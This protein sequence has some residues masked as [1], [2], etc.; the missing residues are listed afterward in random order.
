MQKKINIKIKLKADIAS[1]IIRL[2]NSA[3]KLINYILWPLNKNKNI[4]KICIHR[5]GAIG[6]MLCILPAIYSIRKKYPE[7]HI[8]LLTSTGKNATSGISNFAAALPW[9][10]CIENYVVQNKTFE[11]MLSLMRKIRSQKIDMWVAMPQNSTNIKREIRDMIF[12]KL[13][14]SKWAMG[15]N[16]RIIGLYKKEQALVNEFIKEGDYYIK[17]FKNGGI[18]K[19]PD[20]EKYIHLP[21]GIDFLKASVNF[22]SYRVPTL[23]IAPG[24]KRQTNRWPVERFSE[25]ANRWVN[26]GGL[27]VVVGSENE[28]EIGAEIEKINEKKIINLCGKTTLIETLSLMKR[29]SVALTNDSGPM[30]MAAAVELPLVVVFSARDFPVLWYPTGSR[31]TILRKLVECSP[32]LAENCFNN[33]LCLK[34]I[35]TDEVWS[36]IESHYIITH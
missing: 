36:N 11:S 7:A 9:I 10:D 2:N 23:L 22:N 18:G 4:N 12:A 32:C 29:C 8:T 25:I 17:L 27:V 14:G 31:S 3:I 16:V 20:Q 6:D 35:T 34:N 24:A 13:S 33:N 21:N 26:K 1:K 30:H 19:E 28:V 15:F 5:V